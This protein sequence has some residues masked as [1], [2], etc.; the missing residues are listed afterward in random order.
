[1]KHTLGFICSG[2]VFSIMFFT[3]CSPEEN[4]RPLLQFLSPTSKVSHMPSFTLTA[5]GSDFVDGAT[6]VFDNIEKET[7]FVSSS[8]LTCRI[9]PDETV[10][11]TAA[12][13]TGSGNLPVRSYVAAYDYNMVVYVRNPTPG[14]GDSE[15]LNFTIKSNHTFYSPQSIASSSRAL[16]EPSIA[17]DDPGNINV[18]WYEFFPSPCDIYFSRS[19]DEGV[20]WTQAINVSNTSGVSKV[21]AIVVD[22]TGKLSIAWH[23]NSPGEF[24]IYF[25]TST[26]NGVIWSQVKNISSNSEE[27]ARPRMAVDSTGNLNLVWNDM[28]PGNNEI[29][30]SRST[31]GGAAWSTP[32]NIS[33]TASRSIHPRI[34][35]DSAGNLNAAWEDDVTGVYLI[36]FSRS[37]DNGQTWST[38]V[39][40]YNSTSGNGHAAL[41]VDGEGN[42]ILF[43]IGYANPATIVPFF[44]RSTDGGQTWS[45]PVNVSNRQGPSYSNTVAVDSAGNI[46]VAWYEDN[47]SPVEIYYT[48]SIDNGASWFQ[49]MNISNNSSASA[50]PSIAVD[51][52]GN[53]Y[54]VWQ[55]DLHG[56]YEIFYAG[57]IH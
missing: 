45:T 4:P 48:R 38:P 32:V 50:I 8:E 29:L 11:T 54:I 37:T 51:G 55:D 47:P 43:F 57:S 24:D 46:N 33:K 26:D 18:A 36:H 23:D 49:P 2:I 41:A 34:T 16:W 5:T 3:A 17:V 1:M 7:T 31:D 12:L 56:R 10:S 35:V 40:V 30:F 53:V 25:S 20:S 52:A 6:I 22:S 13:Q 9:D 15:A 44:C 42:I 14:G 39:I 27:S 21:P 19:A 28:A